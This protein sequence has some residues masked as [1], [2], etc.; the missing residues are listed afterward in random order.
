M[1]TKYRFEIYGITFDHIE[2]GVEKIFMTWYGKTEIAKIHN[3]KTV[4]QKIRPL[5][6]FYDTPKFVARWHVMFEENSLTIDFMGESKI[7]SESLASMVFERWWDDDMTRFNRS[8]FR[9]RRGWRHSTVSLSVW[10]LEWEK[11]NCKFNLLMSQI[12]TNRG[13]DNLSHLYNIHL[14]NTSHE[15][16]IFTYNI[17][18]KIIDR[19]THNKHQTGFLLPRFKFFSKLAI[20]CSMSSSF[21]WSSSMLS[22]WL[23]CNSRYCCW[24]GSTKCLGSKFPAS[25]SGDLY[26]ISNKTTI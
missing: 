15:C 11:C 13:N 16:Q 18:K 22:E 25:S 17:K 1:E 24:M 4:S 10:Q 19:M 2:S 21:C 14:Q 7:R 6:V 12:Q 9:L 5:H 3:F 20:F 8:L 23:S 26:E